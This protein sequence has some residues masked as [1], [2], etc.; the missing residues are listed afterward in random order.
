MLK[1]YPCIRPALCLILNSTYYANNYASIFDAGLVCYH[2]YH[3]YRLKT[4][5][6]LELS[7]V[8]HQTSLEPAQRPNHQQ[9]LAAFSG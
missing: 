3:W 1:Y 9:S 8:G 5:T 2:Q 7:L 4:S 6:V